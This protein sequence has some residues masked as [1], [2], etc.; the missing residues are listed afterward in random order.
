MRLLSS[1]QKRPWMLQIAK[2]RRF[3]KSRKGESNGNA[4][5]TT[6]NVFAIRYPEKV[7]RSLAKVIAS[8]Y[9]ISVRQVYKIRSKQAWVHI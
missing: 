9:G 4:K 5:L 2:K 1:Y 8:V 6:K 3:L 7:S